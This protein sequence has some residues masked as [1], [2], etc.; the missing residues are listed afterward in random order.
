MFLSPWFAV[1]GLVLAAGPIVI[2]LM[3]RQRFR[4]IE[5]AAMEFLRQAMRR[6]R[7]L[8]RVQDLLLLVV[9]VLCV[10]LF[11]L[12]MARPFVA[13]SGQVADPNQPV[14]AV[15][16][17]D[18]SM[19]MGYG[20]LGRTVLDEAKARA[21]ECIDRL[22]PGSRISVIPVCASS[23]D[24]SLGAYS[25]KE[26]AAEALESIQPLDRAATAAAALDLAKEA[27]RRTASPAN[28]QI[29]LFS[30]QQA[31]NWPSQ[32]FDA[33]VAQ[34]GG[35]LQVV[36]LAPKEPENAWI[37]DFHL[38]DGIADLDTPAVFLATVRFEGSA[39]RRGVQVSL[40][41]DGA[42][43]AT[44]TVDLEPGQAREIRFPPYRFDQPLQ[45]GQVG[46]VPA[47]VSMPPD[48][49]ATDDRRPLVVPLVSALPVVMVDQ[50]GADESAERNRFG[51]TRRLRQLLAPVT[52]RQGRDPQP[53]K[54]RANQRR[55][56][57]YRIFKIKP[58]NKAE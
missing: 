21:K 23:R 48:H 4:V 19:S 58:K 49:L 56:L 41:V 52:A 38:Q 15:L 6:S 13:G 53:I 44:Q 51:E 17:I 7:R 39:P 27:C 12:A 18:N 29:V 50:W 25:T 34:L 37:A 24:F 35:P 55:E 46:Y 11:G 36:Q 9:R 1:A 20:Q 33:Q 14:H 8:V 22:P 26:D 2:H 3:N 43:F 54:R 32:P 40:S 42:V 5:W 16:L 57:F 45:P 47:E 31:V 10:L 30:D 28:K